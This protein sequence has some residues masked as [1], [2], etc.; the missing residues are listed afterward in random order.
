MDIERDPYAP[1]MPQPRCNICGRFAYKQDGFDE[2]G[3]IIP[4]GG[5][6]ALSCVSWDGYM[7]AWEHD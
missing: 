7:E 6:W 3:N 2:N 1:D 4:K 5:R